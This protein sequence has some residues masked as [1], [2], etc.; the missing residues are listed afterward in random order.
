M[1][2]NIILFYC[3]PYREQQPGRAGPNSA[4]ADA[5]T[6]GI[7]WK[8]TCNSEDFVAGEKENLE[9]TIADHQDMGRS[10]VYTYYAKGKRNCVCFHKIVETH[11]RNC[12]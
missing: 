4:G 3:Q 9:T 11:L 2:N 12:L 10:R 5:A 7:S 1:I 6:N 8:E